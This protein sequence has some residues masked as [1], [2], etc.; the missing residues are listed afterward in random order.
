MKQIQQLLVVTLA[1]LP[2]GRRSMVWFLALAVCL[3]LERA[4]AFNIGDRVQCTTSVGLK[5]HSAAYLSSSVIDYAYLNDQGTVEGGPYYDSSSGYTFYYV[6]WDTHSA[7]YSAQ[8]YLQ[9]ITS[10]PAPSISNVSPNP[11]TADAGNAYQTLTIN[12]ANF[13][14]KPTIILTWTGQSGYTLPASQVTYY[15]NSQLTI[16]IKLGAAADSWTVQVINPDGKSSSPAGFVVNP[17]PSQPVLTVNPANPP[18]QP[19]TAGSVSFN[20]NN[21]GSGTMSYSASVTSG[22]S[23]LSITSGGSGG[24]S[25]TIVVSYSANN[26]GSQ[27]SGTIQVSAGGASGSP[28]TLTITQSSSTPST[29]PVYGKGD[30]I[31]FMNDWSGGKGCISILG[32]SDMQGLVNYEKNRGVQWLAVKCGDGNYGVQNNSYYDAYYANQFNST[33]IT[34]C[35]NAGIKVLGWAFVYGGAAES[36]NIPTDV[37][38]EIAVATAALGLGPDGFIIDWENQYESLGDATAVAHADQYCQGIRTSYPYSTTFLAHAPIWDPNVNLADFYMT[39]GKYCQVVMPQAYCSAYATPSQTWLNPVA[40]A[41][42]IQDLDSAWTTA[43]NSWISQGHAD[44]VKPIVPLAYGASPVTG[45]EIVDFV[46]A[47]K[48]DSTPATSGGYQGVSFYDCDAH[49]AD[50][51]NAMASVTIG[52]A[53][54]PPPSDTTP[55]TITVFGVNPRSVSLGAGFTISYRELPKTPTYA[56]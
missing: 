52:S 55:P 6:V 54:P 39:F 4:L 48:N 42:M 35:H 27:R 36:G 51:W 1:H 28:V 16:S 47:L 11:I 8:D 29:F 34:L 15:G 46:N 50:I 19:A 45:Q 24:N 2:A 9:L 41:Q 49:T 18:T 44:S 7:G 31:R 37:N 17:P 56:D 40:P 3:P 14:N 38:G 30:W 5:I 22:S 43:Q 12:G 21:T 20:V 53:P 13:V 26:T 33:L 32:V 25:G 23:W 10:T